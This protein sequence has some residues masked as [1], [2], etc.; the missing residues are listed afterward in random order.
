MAISGGFI[1]PHQRNGIKSATVVILLLDN[2]DSFTY[3]LVDYFFQLGVKCEVKR[4]DVSISAITAQKY[5]GVVLS[6]GGEEPSK[7][8]ILMDVLDYY[9]GKLPILGICLGHQAIGQYFGAQLVKAE[10]PMHGKLSKIKCSEHPMFGSIPKKH[11]VVRYNSLLLA[12]VDDPLKI[13]A[14][15]ANGEVMAVTHKEMPIWG[16]QYHP[17]AALSQ[18]GLETLKNWVEAT[19]Q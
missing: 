6:P 15:T 3:N 18:Y 19:I 16:V 13:I 8:G 12:D 4:N 9:V 7:A 17:E 11:D 10:N 2:Y 5:D 14:Q 1:S